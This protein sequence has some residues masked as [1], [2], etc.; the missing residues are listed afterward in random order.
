VLSAEQEDHLYRLVGERVR[1]R[2]TGRLTQVK[3]AQMVR[4]ARTS[5][6][7]LERGKQRLPLHLLLRIADALNCELADLMPGSSEL[8]LAG[9]ATERA[10]TDVVIV[11]GQITPSMRAIL[12]RYSNSEE[13][14][15]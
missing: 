9:G 11:G 7:N 10:L 15:P 1:L 5:L 14:R 12:A 6:T 3:L 13:A 8:G 2:R 4:I